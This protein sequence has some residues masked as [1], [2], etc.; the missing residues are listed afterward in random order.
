MA[1]ESVGIYLTVLKKKDLFCLD[2]STKYRVY[3]SYYSLCLT[4]YKLG[5]TRI[6]VKTEVHL[7]TILVKVFL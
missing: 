6:F 4:R 2:C 1:F 5:F 7:R 3:N